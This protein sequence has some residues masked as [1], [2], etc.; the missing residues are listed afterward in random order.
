MQYFQI[1]DIIYLFLDFFIYILRKFDVGS[2][3]GFRIKCIC[4]YLPFRVGI[5]NLYCLIFLFLKGG[6][7]VQEYNKNEDTTYLCNYFRCRNFAWILTFLI[8]AGRFST[9]D[10]TYKDNNGTEKTR[11]VLSAGFI[12]LLLPLQYGGCAERSDCYCQQSGKAG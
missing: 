10:I 9:H 4:I 6:N 1:V 8:P 7:Y 5:V 11:T 12:P 2:I 3:I